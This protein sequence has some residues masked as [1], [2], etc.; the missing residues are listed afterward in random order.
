MFEEQMP[1][2]A[3]GTRRV[4][5]WDILVLPL[6]VKEALAAAVTMINVKDI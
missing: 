4:G 5:L 6:E 2:P 1:T 3:L